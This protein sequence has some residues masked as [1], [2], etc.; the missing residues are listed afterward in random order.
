MP[1][2]EFI[3]MR[4][5][6]LSLVLIVSSLGLVV[7][8][9]S[10]ARSPGLAYPCVLPGLFVLLSRVLQLLSAAYTYPAYSYPTYYPS[11]YYGYYPG[12]SNYSAYPW[13]SYYPTY[14]YYYGW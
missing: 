11:Y 5:L 4:S 14:S 8:T 12:Y 1:D 3:R 7:A 10:Q 6:L 9:P 13:Y 2:E